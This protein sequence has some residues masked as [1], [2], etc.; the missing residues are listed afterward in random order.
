MGKKLDKI[1]AAAA[2]VLARGIIRGLRATMRLEFVN[3]EKYRGGSSVGRQMI[4]AFWHGRLHDAVLL[5]RQWHIHTRQPEQG[6]RAH[7]EDREGFWSGLG[8]GL[9]HKGL[10]RGHKGPDEGRQG[11]A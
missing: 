11:W 7:S 2:P 3:C 8:K 6:R 9:D 4:L 5:F 10:V 1:V